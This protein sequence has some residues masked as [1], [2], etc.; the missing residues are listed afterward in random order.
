MITYEVICF[1]C[2]QSFH[3][4]EGTKKYQYYKRNMTGKFSCDACEDKIY[5][6]AR[7]N[8]ISKLS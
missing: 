6:E 1:C 2:K 4:V 7:R 8:I 3:V 5:V